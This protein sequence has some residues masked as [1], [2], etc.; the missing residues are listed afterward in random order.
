MN[1]SKPLRLLVV[2]AHPADA[3]DN[4]AGTIAAH[5]ERGD[6]VEI[7]SVTHGARSHAPNVYDDVQEGLDERSERSLLEETIEKKREE[8][9][10]AARVLGVQR[11]PFLAE[12]DEP[13]MASRQA[14]LDVAEVYR[15]A[16]P[17][18]LITHHPTEH[19]HHDHPL[20]G[21]LS[22]RCVVTAARW[23]EGSQLAPYL[24][25][26]VYFYG[27]QSRRDATLVDAAI[28][29]PATHVVDITSVIEKKKTALSCFASQKYQGAAYDTPEY[30][31]RRIESLEGSWGLINEF[32]YAEEFIARQPH[33]LQSLPI[34]RCLA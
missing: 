24:I 10:K 5:V 12:D 6:H 32:R 16:R 3:I 25:S 27:V 29:L 14:A 7:V 33:R 2:T 23:L 4:A 30:M 20:V 17:D 22:L 13:F 11:T 34:S 8:F 19:N 26:T 9:E 1:T 31:N 18:I 21:E 28:R 15:K